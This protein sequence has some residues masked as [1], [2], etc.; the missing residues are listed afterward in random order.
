VKVQQKSIDKIIP[1]ARNPRKNKDAIAKVA[2]SIKEF[3][4]QQSIAVD[5]EMVVAN[6]AI[7]AHCSIVDR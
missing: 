1:Y 2:A 3:G 4:W 7:P 6:N 5:S